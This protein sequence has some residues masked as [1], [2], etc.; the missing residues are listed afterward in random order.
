[1]DSAA[2]IRTA[3]QRTGLTL[4]Q[5]AE[6]AHTSHSTLAAYESG[7]K[8]PNVKTLERILHSAGFATEVTLHR[9]HRGEAGMTKGDELA[10]VLELAAAFPARHAPTMQA[11]VFGRSLPT[12]PCQRLRSSEGGPVRSMPL[13]WS[14]VSSPSTT[15]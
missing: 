3:R 13:I 15:L 2:L 8:V 4:R 5:L 7:S 12:T 6:Q 9:R 10:A 14:N 11:P 1:M